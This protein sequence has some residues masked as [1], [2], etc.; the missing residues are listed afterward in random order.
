MALKGIYSRLAA[1][2]AFLVGFEPSVRPHA[3]MP[4]YPNPD[5]FLADL[6]VVKTSL[7][8]HRASALAEERLDP[9]IRGVEAFGFHLA[10]MDVRQNSKVHEAVL[11][12]LL[13]AA[14]VVA[15][16]AALEEDAKIE[17]LL[18]ELLSPRPLVSAHL[19]YSA[20]VQTELGVVNA[21]RDVHRRFGQRAVPQYVISNCV[22]VSDI[23]EVAMLL[24]EG[25]LCAGPNVRRP[26]ILW[27]TAPVHALAHPRLP[28]HPAH[29][30][31]RAP[32]PFPRLSAP[33]S[34][35]PSA[36]HT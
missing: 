32:A 28:L 17:L 21:V 6:R 29:A 20:L 11:T 12:E 18:R 23:L 34:R 27:R 31:S 26:P 15:D 19:Q 22:S 1:T 5:A 16:Y 13:R 24:K 7:E 9:L 30:P 14:D 33:P 2:A 4:V 36:V 35:S 25:G 8:G 3:S 10:V